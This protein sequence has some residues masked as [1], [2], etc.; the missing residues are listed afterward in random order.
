MDIQAIIDIIT[1]EGGALG[2][3]AIA[4]YFMYS[5]RLVPKDTLK[6]LKEENTFL[7]QTVTQLTDS[8]NS[9]EKSSEESLENSRTTLKILSAARESTGVK[10]EAI[11]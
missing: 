11:D 7:R 2:L 1:G 6:D 8:V 10:G 9:M 5:G 3:L 4:L